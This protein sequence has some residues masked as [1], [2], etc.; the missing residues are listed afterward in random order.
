MKTTVCVLAVGAALLCVCAVV[1]AL[2]SGA[3]VTLN[4]EEVEGPMR[5]LAGAFGLG[6]TVITLVGVGLL[7]VAI[8]SG[9]GLVVAVSLA[10]TGAILIAVACP[11]IA[12]ILVPFLILVACCRKAPRRRVPGRAHS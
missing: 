6:V 10:L 9:V 11:L 7:L 4:G 3:S 8:F 1:W 2:Y 12:P 5:L